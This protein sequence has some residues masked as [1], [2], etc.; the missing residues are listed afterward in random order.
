M[1]KVP[2]Q[3]G[4]VGSCKVIYPDGGKIGRGFLLLGFARGV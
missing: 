3:I 4:M 1:E 2:S